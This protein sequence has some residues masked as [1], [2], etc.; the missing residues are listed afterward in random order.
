LQFEEGRQ[1]ITTKATNVVYF[2]KSFGLG[3]ARIFLALAL[4]RL[5]VLALVLAQKARTWP[6]PWPCIK[7]LDYKTGI[8]T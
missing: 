3:L 5:K 4:P 1:D 7:G 2:L 6:W 8:A